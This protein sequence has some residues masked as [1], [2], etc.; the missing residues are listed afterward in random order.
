MVKQHDDQKSIISKASSK[1][2]NK[3]GGVKMKTTTT[4]KI[5][6]LTLA[7]LAVLCT[8]LMTLT[9]DAQ[10]H[11]SYTGAHHAIAYLAEKENRDNKLKA[12]AEKN[13]TLTAKV[14]VKN[15]QTDY[16]NRLNDTTPAE[17]SY[18]TK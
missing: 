10:S 6:V 13:N 16:K 18:E 17:Y 9:V 5:A 11:S 8:P 2:A 7:V 1:G 3:K 14:E 12:E 4:I 15:D